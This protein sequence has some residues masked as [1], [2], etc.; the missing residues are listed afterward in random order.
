MITVAMLAEFQQEWIMQIFTV[1][2]VVFFVL[3][4]I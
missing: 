3:K 1:I 4:C 2:D